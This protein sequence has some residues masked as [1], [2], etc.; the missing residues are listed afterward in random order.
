MSLYYLS[1][2]HLLACVMDDATITDASLEKS[3]TRKPA[4]VCPVANT[5]HAQLAKPLASIH[6]HASV[7]KQLSAQVLRSSTN[8]LAIASVHLARMMTAKEGANST[9]NCAS[10]CRSAQRMLHQNA[11]N[12]RISIQTRAPASALPFL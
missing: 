9:R 6:V 5:V 12:C 4:P 10:V 2:W 1:R 11:T 3:S 7:F 8:V